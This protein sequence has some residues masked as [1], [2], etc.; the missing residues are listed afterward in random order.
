MERFV[1]IVCGMLPHFLLPLPVSDM[2]ACLCAS[3]LCTTR[4]TGWTV[5]CPPRPLQMPDGTHH[6]RARGFL[7]FEFT[8]APAH[9]T[10]QYTFVSTPL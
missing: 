5:A 8:S 3:L 1:L 7:A 6:L 4:C 2:A 9:W 10:S